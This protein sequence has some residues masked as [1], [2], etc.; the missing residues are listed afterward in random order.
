MNCDILN[1]IFNY[2]DLKSIFLARYMNKYFKNFIDNDF[3]LEYFIIQKENKRFHQEYVVNRNILAKHSK[4]LKTIDISI[5]NLEINLFN[6]KNMIIKT[7]SAFQD[8][9][10][11]DDFI[12][13]FVGGNLRN[14]TL[15]GNN[16]LTCNGIK[17]LPS[18][19][20][21]V[22]ISNNTFTLLPNI[23]YTRIRPLK[24]PVDL[25]TLVLNDC[26]IQD[27][28]IAQLKNLE[29]LCLDRN[30]SITDNG[31]HNLKNLK[32]LRLQGVY[33]TNEGLR[34]LSKIEYLE[35]NF[36]D[37][38]TDEG[39]EFIKNVKCLILPYNTKI[40]ESGLKLLKN[41]ENFDLHRNPNLTEFSNLFHKSKNNK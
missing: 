41:L 31:L 11:D 1:E 14:L 5:K 2:L 17:M 34:Y 18:L 25:K 40:T 19:Q 24:F 39:L 22:L 37:R 35:I 7:K 38:I 10:I 28:D 12:L 21:L 8:D 20:T 33:I 23:T 16:C 36:N 9:K 32:H 3:E 30:N 29:R 27:N 6:S 15:I 13:N 26:Y 4:T